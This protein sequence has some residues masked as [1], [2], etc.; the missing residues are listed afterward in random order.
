MR[1]ARTFEGA[2]ILIG[3]GAV[4]LLW[5]TGYIP[6]DWGQWWPVLL[7][8]LGVLA[9][10]IRAQQA[11]PTAAPPGSAASPG[12]PA[13]RPRRV[14]GGVFLVALGA[15]FLVS[16]AIGRGSEAPLLLIAIGLAILVSRYR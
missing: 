14:G 2:F 11:G 4:L 16:N 9:V 15:A 13:R 12:A 5:N 8:L 7:I 1:R 3:I 10:I 6:R